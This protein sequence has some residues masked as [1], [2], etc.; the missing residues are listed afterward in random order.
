M[1]LVRINYDTIYFTIVE[2]TDIIRASLQNE[3]EKSD[4]FEKHESQLRGLNA[5]YNQFFSIHVGHVSDYI[6]VELKPPVF[7]YDI[8]VLQTEDKYYFEYFIAYAKLHFRIHF[9]ITDF[10]FLRADLAIDYIGEWKSFTET[11]NN[12][13]ARLKKMEITKIEDVGYSIS[14]GRS[15]YIYAKPYEIIRYEKS[16]KIVSEDK[17]YF[18]PSIYWENNVIR[19]EIRIKQEKLK[20]YSKKRQ[21]MYEIYK[22]LLENFDEID[23]NIIRD[24]LEPTFLKD[25]KTVKRNKTEYEMIREKIIE[26]LKNQVEALIA[27]DK[28]AGVNTTKSDLTAI[29]NQLEIDTSKKEKHYRNTLRVL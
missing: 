2:Q 12:H 22:K 29:I 9:D 4:V 25:I 1:K 20:Q 21:I 5:Y 19:L 23:I 24:M 14:S 26:G 17:D 15:S 13:S 8:P 16:K 18:Y 11:M 28:V 10:R 6:K 3:L 7:W 27:V